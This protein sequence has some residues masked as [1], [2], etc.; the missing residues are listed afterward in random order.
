MNKID[1]RYLQPLLDE[2][3]DINNVKNSVRKFNPKNRNSASGHGLTIFGIIASINAKN[4]VE[5]GVA[6]GGTTL[7]LLLATYSNGG[8]LTCVDKGV[9]PINL[10]WVPDLN[11]PYLQNHIKLIRDDSINFL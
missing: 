9:F 4:V 11:L 10:T 7:S 2:T 1:I 3:L 8:F 6:Q 5:L